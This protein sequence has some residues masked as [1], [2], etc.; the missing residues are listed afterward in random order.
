MQRIQELR[1]SLGVPMA[2]FAKA[3]GVSEQVVGQ[4]ESGEAE[5][6]IPALR[7]IATLLGTNV[8]DLMDFANNGRRMTSQHWMPGDDAIFDG[9]WG[10]MG[11]LLPGETSCSWYPITFAEYS[12]V[13]ES[14]SIEHA[15]PQWLVVSTLNNRKLLINPALIRRIRLLDEAADRP[16]DDA[17]QH[18]WDSEEGLLP[19]LYRALGEYFTDELAF[20]A[21]NSPVAQQIIHT[22][23]AKHDLT[24]A[25]VMHLISHTHV[26]LANGSTASVRAANADIY[27]L[28]LDAYAGMPLGISLSTRDT[29]EENHFSPLQVA[30]V[31]IPLLQYQAAEI[32]ASA[33]MEGV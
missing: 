24:S 6:G 29:E 30:L 10:R 23:V 5:P 27:N 9:F 22:L 13:A 12:Q 28:V 11:L 33:E 26:H 21:N 4:W 32:E 25:K 8:D 2:D 17:W 19:E 31:D 14:L 1:T 15:E 20:D 16:E 3:L 18:G 7:D